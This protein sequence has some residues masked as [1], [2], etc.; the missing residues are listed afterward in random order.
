MRPHDFKRPGFE[1]KQEK[2]RE[3]R[4]GVHPKASFQF[5][6]GKTPEVLRPDEF[7]GVSESPR[8]FLSKTR[9]LGGDSFEALKDMEQ[10]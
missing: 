1:T 6:L 7:Q 9:P 8:S 3:L 2:T 4:A 5:L 10:A